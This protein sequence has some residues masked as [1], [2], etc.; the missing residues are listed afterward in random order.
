MR[1]AAQ[2]FLF[3]SFSGIK[4]KIILFL[5]LDV[6]WSPDSSPHLGDYGKYE[7]SLSQKKW[8]ARSDVTHSTFAS[9]QRVADY[10]GSIVKWHTV[11]SNGLPTGEML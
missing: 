6:G 7:E 9:F 1:D 3:M 2:N 4:L 10:K 5:L 11:K 8:P